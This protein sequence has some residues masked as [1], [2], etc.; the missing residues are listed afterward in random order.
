MASVLALPQTIEKAPSAAVVNTLTIDVEDYYQVSGFEPWVERS[1]WDRF[2]SRVERGTDIILGRLAEANVRATFFTLGWV[3][4]RRPGLV[5]AIQAAGHEIASHGHAHRLIY[6]Q[7]PEEFRA[8]V[9]QARDILE[10][11]SG[12]P[13]RAYRAPSFSITARSL[14]AL[15]VLIDEGFV[16]DSSIYPVYHDRYGIPGTPLEPH[17]IDRPGGTIWEFPPPVWKVLGC[18]VPVGGG[19]YFRLY[20]YPVTRHGLRSINAAGR[21]FAV[22]LHPWEFDPE[23]PRLSVGRMRAWRHYVNLHRTEGRLIRLLSDFAFAPL[24]DALEN[25]LGERPRRHAA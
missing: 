15:D 24:S 14:W 6:T 22:Y 1:N 21:P 9:R 11:I 8:D 12:E 7:T 16:Y 4:Q 23:Q 2:E 3:A 13:I 19:G 17:R 25:Y 20:P 18:P 5:R 10:D